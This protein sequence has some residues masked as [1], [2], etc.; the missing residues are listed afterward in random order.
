MGELH[1]AELS[2]SEVFMPQTTPYQY[3]KLGS[4]LEFLRGLA[5]ASVIQTTSLAAFPGLLENLSVRRYSV[6]NVVNALTSL[7]VQLQEM[8]LEQSLHVAEPLRAML[9]EMENYVATQKNPH[10]ALLNDP[11]AERLLAL[12]RKLGSAVRSELGMA[13]P[14]VPA[15]T[16]SGQG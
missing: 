14:S 3:V 12:S 2:R 9:S 7:L 15:P 16:G 8:G 5:T 10:A 6:T 4:N 13:D 1:P 11:F